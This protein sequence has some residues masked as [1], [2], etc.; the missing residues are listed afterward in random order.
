[1]AKSSTVKSSNTKAGGG[2]SGGGN[3]NRLNLVGT[4]GADSLFGGD[5]NDVL[6]GRGGN[7]N[8]YGRAGNDYLIGGAG[9]DFLDGGTNYDQMD[10]GAGNDT[11]VV[12][13]ASDLVVERFDGGTDTVLSSI[14]YQLMN[15]Q[16]EN[17]TM[18]GGNA[19]NGTGSWL[20]NQLTGNAAANRLEGREGNDVIDGKAGEDVLVGGL[21]ADT[22]VFSTAPG[23]GDTNVYAAS[24]G[25]VGGGNVDHILDFQAG[26]DRIALDDSVF[27]GLTVGA[28]DPAAFAVGAAADA[29]DRIVYDPTTGAV[30]F[31]S[32][33]VGGA[34]A[35]VFATVQ[36][37]VDLSAASFVVI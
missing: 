26:V 22:F 16:I 18:I 27:T 9:D 15:D 35:I 17:L 12:D 6:D 36:P 28:L 10:G 25:T 30:S 13:H 8:L 33:G 31:D 32:D 2:K 7:D 4:E 29:D 1:M 23:A 34:A 3:P 5:G 19:V 20:D 21:G 37:G 11:Y 14:S 24:D